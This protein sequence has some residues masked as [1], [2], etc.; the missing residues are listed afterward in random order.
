LAKVLLVQVLILLALLMIKLVLVG[1][2]AREGPVV[3]VGLLVLVVPQEQEV[4][5]LMAVELVE[6]R[7]LGVLA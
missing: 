5:E 2:V 1:L 7:I 6:H 3:V 4:V